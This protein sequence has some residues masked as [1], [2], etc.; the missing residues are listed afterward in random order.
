MDFAPPVQT[1][2]EAALSRPTGFEVNRLPTLQ[3]SAPNSGLLPP[4]PRTLV[5]LHVQC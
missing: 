1:K 2:L 4:D 5:A 3:D